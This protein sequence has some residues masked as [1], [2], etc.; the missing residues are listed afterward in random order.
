V[1]IEIEESRATHGEREVD[2]A[3]HGPHQATMFSYLSPERRVPSDHPLRTLRPMVDDALGKLSGLFDAMYAAEG[4]RSIPPEK[5]L[6]AL[7][8]Q[9]LYT[10]A[11]GAL[12]RDRHVRSARTMRP[13]RLHSATVAPT[14]PASPAD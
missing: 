9:L 3:G 8:L 14:T 12:A 5:L 2:D 13:P 11:H 10:V 7:I 1:T 4:R 6:R